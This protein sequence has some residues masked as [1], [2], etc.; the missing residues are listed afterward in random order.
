MRNSVKVVR[1]FDEVEGNFG[2]VEG[3]FGEV[4]TSRIEVGGNFDGVGGNFGRVGCNLVKVTGNFG[5]VTDSGVKVVGSHGKVGGNL[6]RG[7]AFRLCPAPCCGLR[8][9]ALRLFPDRELSQLAARGRTRDAW[10]NFN[11]ILS[12][13]ALRIETIRAPVLPPAR[14]LLQS[15]P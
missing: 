6:G 9:S 11:V 4:A 12:V 7:K 3:N 1:N 2:E 10:D 14:F 15:L 8:Q 13:P 5:K